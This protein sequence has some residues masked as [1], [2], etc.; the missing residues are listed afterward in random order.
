[1]ELW[2]LIRE[3]VSNIWTKMGPFQRFGSIAVILAL[4]VTLVFLINPWKAS[5]LVPLFTGLRADDAGEVVAVLREQGITYQLASNGSTVLV[6]ANQVHDLRLDLASQGLPK[7]G[8]VGFEV[9]QESQLGTTDFERRLKYIW[10][11]QGELTRTI[12]ELQEVEDARVHIVMPE[13]SLFLDQER[14]ATASVLLRLIPG[15]RLN[16]SQVRGIGHLVARSVEG[17][18]PENVTIIDTNG[19]ILS[20]AP[21][22]LWGEQGAVSR[23]QLERNY[24]RDLELR[25]QTMLERVFGLGN[26][27]V[28]A[29]VQLNLNLQEERAEIFEPIGRG[30]GILRSEQTF[31]EMS[32]GVY[33][34]AGGPAGMASNIPG[35]VAGEAQEGQYERRE[36]IRNYEIS[37]REQI[38][39][40]APGQ[41][42]KLSLAIWVD[43]ADPVQLGMIEEAVASAVGLDPSRGDQLIVDNMA[44]SDG[45]LSAVG[46]L[47]Q[48]PAPRSVWPWF[49]A[50]ICGLILL[51]MIL[52]RPRAAEEID[53]VVDEEIP[54]IPPEPDEQEELE[55]E[56]QDL[57]KRSPQDVA[58]VLRTW[59]AGD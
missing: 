3:Q 46:A 36:T 57:A 6:P 26:A 48:Q 21:A 11:L 22:N 34:Q 50:G 51:L 47:E 28:R 10:A 12:R 40:I 44:F 43:G 20:E 31:E 5:N 14:E 13:R 53:L 54:V 59:M 27:L 9:F 37:R 39:S 38:F 17:L 32:Q 33:G 8:V 29:N 1:M 15:T 4:I 45:V 49:I 2:Q 23:F 35:Y 55:R 41:V 24:A 19:N 25:I 58:Q 56:I 18:T 7:G 52:R 16:A 42:E 30:Q